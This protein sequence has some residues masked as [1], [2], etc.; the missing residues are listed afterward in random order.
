MRNIDFANV[1]LG[2]LDNSHRLPVKLKDIATI[3]DDL[4]D[5]RQVARVNGEPAVGIGIVKVSN[6]NTVA[7]QAVCTATWTEPASPGASY[8]V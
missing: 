3:H 7:S 1:H 4:A 6:G 5:F 2:V 8:S